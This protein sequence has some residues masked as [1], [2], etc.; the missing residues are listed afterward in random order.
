[1]EEV[2]SKRQK[3]DVEKP[4]VKKWYPSS[5][6]TEKIILEEIS[7]PSIKYSHFCM[8]CHSHIEDTFT[9]EPTKICE[10]CN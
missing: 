9:D 5:G 2:Q 10:K 1:M 7:G 4:Y 3:M 8:E 6:R